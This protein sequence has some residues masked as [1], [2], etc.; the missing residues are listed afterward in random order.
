MYEALNSP[1][2]NNDEM[3]MFSPRRYN[4]HKHLGNRE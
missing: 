4:S 2:R 3:Y 1:K